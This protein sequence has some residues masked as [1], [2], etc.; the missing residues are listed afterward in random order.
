VVASSPIKHD[1][2]NTPLSY[3]NKSLTI[4]W[5]RTCLCGWCCE[6]TAQYLLAKSLLLRSEPAVIYKSFSHLQ[7]MPYNFYLFI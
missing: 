6:I 2:E 5:T 4:F 1:S 3:W 7:H